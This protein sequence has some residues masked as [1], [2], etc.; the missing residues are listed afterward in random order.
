MSIIRRYLDPIRSRWYAQRSIRQT[1][2]QQTDLTIYLRLDDVYSYLAVQILDDLDDIL[3]DKIKP[4]H[5]LIGKNKA[6]PPNG[7][8]QDDWQNYC[9]NDAKILA[10][11]HGFSYDDV[12]EMPSPQAIEQAYQ[13]LERSTL[14]GRDFLYLLEDIFHM[15]WQQ[16][17]GK[18][19]TLYLLSEQQPL[20]Q[21]PAF[22][23]TQHPILTAHFKFAHREYHAVDGLLRLTRRLQQLKLLTTAPIFLI[24]HIEW[25]EHLIQGVEEIADIQALQPELDLYIAL[26][27][28]MTWLILA[29]L[30]TQLLDYYNIQLRLYPIEYQAKDNFDWSVLYRLTRRAGVEFSPFCRPTA[31][32][33]IQ[34]AKLFYSVDEEKQNQAMYSILQAVWT[35]GKDFSYLPH[36]NA[37]YEQLNV[38][39]ITQDIYQRLA[40]NTQKCLSLKQPS[41][42][43]LVL[44]IDGQEYCFNSAYRLWLIECILS[45]V[46]EK[47]YKAESEMDD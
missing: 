7:M 5:I 14:T 20:N 1:E 3:V 36:Y 15:L 23:Y 11:Q 25:R 46:L 38:S 16:Q 42:P 40:E 28:P 29:Y 9:L 26:E 4:L 6:V 12:P 32:A 47:R 31:T 45:K 10:M 33:S 37:M 27:D 2:I 22:Q 39:P 34:M 19:N 35:Q 24:N 18:L 8:T 21:Q 17:Y 41:S 13:I 43:V 44:R 30:K